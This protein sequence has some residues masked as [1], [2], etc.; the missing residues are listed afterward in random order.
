MRVRD[1]EVEH[2]PVKS[3]CFKSGVRPGSHKQANDHMFSSQKMSSNAMPSKKFNV[4]SYRV[5]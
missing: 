5:I 3:Q 1:A 2:F 4:Y